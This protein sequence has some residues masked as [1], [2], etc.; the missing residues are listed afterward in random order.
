MRVLFLA[1]AGVGLLL[2][3]D[4]LVVVWQGAQARW[5]WLGLL[6]YFW[7]VVCLAAVAM[8]V[9]RGESPWFFVAFLAY[10]LADALYGFYLAATVPDP[11]HLH[12]P[13]LVVAG[14][15]LFGLGYAWWGWQRWRAG[16]ERP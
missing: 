4:A 9:R 1:G 13:P 8:A 7:F 10:G 15:G 14:Y 3:V 11:Q 6:P 12:L 2:V 5:A 16:G